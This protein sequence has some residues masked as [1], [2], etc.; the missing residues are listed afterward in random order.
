MKQTKLVE[1]KQTEKQKELCRLVKGHFCFLCKEY[2]SVLNF[3]KKGLV[4]FNCCQKKKISVFDVFMAYKFGKDDLFY[5][6][7]LGFVKGQSCKSWRT[8]DKPKV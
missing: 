5:Y 3:T 6:K 4:C 1:K 7:F 2:F 8:D